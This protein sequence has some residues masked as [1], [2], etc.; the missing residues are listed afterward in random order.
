MFLRRWTAILLLIWCAGS[1]CP[2]QS[3]VVKTDRGQTEFSSKAAGP[4]QDIYAIDKTG[5]VAL[6]LSSGQLTA[7]LQMQYF[8]LPRPLMQKHYNERYMQTDKFPNASFKGSVLNWKLPE[9]DGKTTVTASGD[10]TIHGVTRKRQ[11]KG[12]ITKTGNHYLL[13]AAFDVKLADHGIEIPVLFF[14]KIT[15][16]VTVTTRYELM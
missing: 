3:N 5:N 14:T 1:H 12:T 6:D 10:F 11:L 9:K 7:T 2:G 16:S 4:A 13:E 8:S 15:E